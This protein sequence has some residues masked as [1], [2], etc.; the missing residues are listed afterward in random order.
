MNPDDGGNKYLKFAAIFIAAGIALGLLWGLFYLIIRWPIPTFIVIGVIAVVTIVVLCKI[1]MQIKDEIRIVRSFDEK[2]DYK[3]LR[4]VL[5][6]YE[7][8]R[9]KRRLYIAE[10]LDR[11]FDARFKQL[12]YDFQKG[13]TQSNHINTLNDTIQD[14]IHFRPE[15]AVKILN[16][17]NDLFLTEIREMIDRGD[18]HVSIMN[19]LAYI[20]KNTQIPFMVS[21]E[22]E[23]LKF[24]SGLFTLT[25]P[26]A[27]KI[28]R[29][30][31]SE[32]SF[33]FSLAFPDNIVGAF[34]KMTP[35][36]LDSEGMRFD[37]MNLFI[38]YSHIP[39]FDNEKFEGWLPLVS[40][41]YEILYIKPSTVGVQLLKHILCMHRERVAPGGELPE[42][43][44][45][46]IKQG[47][48]KIAHERILA[49]ERKHEEEMN[50]LRESLYNTQYYP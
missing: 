12:F 48:D 23:Y 18:D 14:Y 13:K 3:G 38:P 42:K 6:I 24:K 15:E 21:Y 35:V 37:S 7:S 34:I 39:A 22:N 8:S 16:K 36:T 46:V 44:A 26:L 5:D 32:S 10:V 20:E 11:Y 45:E 19:H 33:T 17:R 50:W 43:V 47:F 27:D 40:D 49:R 25:L 31:S 9:G 1:T 2:Q 29:Q 28:F 4:N 30:T 41:D